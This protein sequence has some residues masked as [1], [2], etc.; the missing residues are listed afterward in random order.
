MLVLSGAEIL[1]PVLM[2]KSTSGRKSSTQA[3]EQI[4]KLNK[5]VTSLTV[6]ESELRRKTDDMITD[7]Y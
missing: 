5:L 7:M 4:K 2:S 6:L 1:C 3:T